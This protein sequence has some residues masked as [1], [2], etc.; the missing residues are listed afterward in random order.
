MRGSS[1]A[2]CTV[3]ILASLFFAG[4]AA[5]S[6]HD[7]LNEAAVIESLN[8]YGTEFNALAEFGL[9]R[10]CNKA[11]TN[12]VGLT[13][14]ANQ[15]VDNVFSKKVLEYSVQQN[16]VRTPVTTVLNYSVGLP[17]VGTTPAFPDSQALNDWLKFFYARIFNNSFS[18]PFFW[19]IDK[20]IVDE[21]VTRDPDYDGASIAYVTASNVNEGYVCQN[22][23]GTPFRI[24]RKQQSVYKFIFRLE[25]DSGGDRDRTTLAWRFIRFHENNKGSVTF[26]V[27]PTQN[28]P[29]V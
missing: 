11:L 13:A 29:I 2:L 9:D 16:T 12:L 1:A 20:P 6:G 18:T 10:T 14:A 15:L 27:L 8:R 22:V 7:F 17:A 3:A 5:T 4:A 26:T 25:D 21:I 24:Y 23:T 19:T 28:Q